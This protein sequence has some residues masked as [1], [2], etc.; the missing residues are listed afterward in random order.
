VPSIPAPQAATEETTPPQAPPPAAPL[1]V[2][3]GGVKPPSQ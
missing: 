2:P 1:L 3:F